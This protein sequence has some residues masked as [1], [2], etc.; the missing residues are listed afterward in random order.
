V[1][2]LFAGPG[3]KGFAPQGLE[4]TWA[5]RPKEGMSG[6]TG[7]VIPGKRT[8]CAKKVDTF[9]KSS[10]RLRNSPGGLVQRKSWRAG[11]GVKKTRGQSRLRNI[12]PSLQSQKENTAVPLENITVGAGRSFSFVSDEKRG[13]KLSRRLSQE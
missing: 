12:S 7:S 4:N 8:G 11:G 9:K 5:S 1:S 3:L 10:R 13:E 6:G 2:G